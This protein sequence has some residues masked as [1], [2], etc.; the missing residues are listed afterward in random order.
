MLVLDGNNS[1]K[2]MKSTRGQ[3]EVGDDRLFDASDYFLSNNY[4]GSFANEVR[5]PTRADTKE[6]PEEE[7]V[8]E[9]EGYAVE[10]GDP[11]LD[12]CASNWKAA[13]STEKKKMWGIFDETGIF[14]SACP[15][16]FV[17]W[18]ADMVQSG[19]LYADF[20]CTP[21]LLY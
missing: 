9:D 16:G 13:A 7:T 15:H 19:E 18:L 3:Q 8:A 5:C 20:H 1:L 2:R 11:E 17:L 12:N 6:E 4:V 14:A 21:S 10:A